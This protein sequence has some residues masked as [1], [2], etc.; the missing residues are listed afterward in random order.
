MYRAV[1]EKAEGDMVTVRFI[2]FGNREMKDK[3]ELLQLS[4]KMAKWPAVAHPII[5]EENKVAEDSQANRDEVEEVL[6]QDLELVMK[7]G[8]LVML[9]ISGKP[10]NF[11][12]NKKSASKGKQAEKPE[13][14]SK[15]PA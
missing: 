9:V 7:G 2:D 6:D 12:F 8:K 3:S 13:T 15:E 14:K 4:E 5:L 11:S 10:V 1:V